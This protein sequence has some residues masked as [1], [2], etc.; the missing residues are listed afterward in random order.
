MAVSSGVAESE[1]K[2][3]APARP[4]AALHP[5]CHVAHCGSSCPATTFVC[6]LIVTKCGIEG[7]EVFDTRWFR[8]NSVGA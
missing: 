7:Q 5:F 4:S 1:K 3:T 8:G 6:A 2:M